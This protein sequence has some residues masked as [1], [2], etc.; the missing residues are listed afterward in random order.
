MRRLI[1][2]FVFSHE[3]KSGFCPDMV[4]MVKSQR[5]H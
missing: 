4:H 3:Q 1:R 5:E 2:V